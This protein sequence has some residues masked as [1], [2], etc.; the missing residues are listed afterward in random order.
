MNET[1]ILK[2]VWLEDLLIIMPE[3]KMCKLITMCYTEI[4]RKSGKTVYCKCYNIPYFTK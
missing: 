2:S 1:L 3:F 4:G